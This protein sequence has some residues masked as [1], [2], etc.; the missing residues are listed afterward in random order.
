MLVF[1]YYNIEL[2]Y[3][4]YFEEFKFCKKLSVFNKKMLY[5]A[6]TSR[7]ILRSYLYQNNFI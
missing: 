5:L 4:Q 2:K 6:E 7:C 3:F 1:E